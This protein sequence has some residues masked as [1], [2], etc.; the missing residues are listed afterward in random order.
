[1]LVT[2]SFLSRQYDFVLYTLL[3]L[4]AC[5]AAMTTDPD[6]RLTTTGRDL[7]N[8]LLLTVGAVVMVKVAVTVLTAWSRG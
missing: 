6:H 8:I 3:G 5:H 2:S 1:V 7:G 4:G